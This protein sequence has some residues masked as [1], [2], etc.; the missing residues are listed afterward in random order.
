MT[1]FRSSLTRLMA[2]LGWAPLADYEDA[3]LANIRLAN[4][5]FKLRRSLDSVSAEVI[6][7]RNEMDRREDERFSG[8]RSNLVGR[9]THDADSLIQ[10]RRLEFRFQPNG[11]RGIELSL[12]LDFFLEGGDQGAISSAAIAGESPSCLFE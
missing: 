5:T 12:A 1:K 11:E 3:K 4:E 2:R 8:L 6:H 9:V 7:L 10:H